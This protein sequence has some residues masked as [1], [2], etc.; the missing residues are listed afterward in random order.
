MSRRS[1]ERRE[2]E[3]RRATDRPTSTVRFNTENHIVRDE[4]AYDDNY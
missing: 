4:H 1:S 3:R 2:A